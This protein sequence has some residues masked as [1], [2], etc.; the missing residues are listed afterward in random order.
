M[1]FLRGG[2]IHQEF[3]T[4]FQQPKSTL[5]CFNVSDILEPVNGLL[6]VLKDFNFVFFLTV[7]NKIF[8]PIDQLVTSFIAERRLRVLFRI[9]SSFVKTSI[10]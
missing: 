1:F 8:A 3:L 9:F 6:A 2:I 5:R 10:L 7:F 4:Q